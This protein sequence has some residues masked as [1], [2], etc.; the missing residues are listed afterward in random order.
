[1]ATAAIFC[2]SGIAARIASLDF[3]WLLPNA[4][5]PLISSFTWEKALAMSS[6]SDFQVLRGHCGFAAFGCAM[7]VSSVR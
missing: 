6:I 4:K 3:R 2:I 7:P 5:R 1:M